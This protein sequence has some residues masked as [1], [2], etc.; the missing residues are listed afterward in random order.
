MDLSEKWQRAMEETKVLHA[1]PHLLSAENST[2]LPYIFLA[3]SEV[4]EGDTVVRKG[5]VV[6]DRP[7]ILLPKNIPQFSGFEL[8]EGMDTDE[9]SLRFFFMLRGIQFPSLKYH[10]EVC[11]LDVFEGNVQKASDHFQHELDKEEEGQT[12]LMVGPACCWQFSVLMYVSTL[13]NRSASSDLQRLMDELRRR[14]GN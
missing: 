4:N 12:G 1:Y 6:V 13:I 9:D 8:E 3:A 2:T 10:N 7:L 14:M 5:K 11:T